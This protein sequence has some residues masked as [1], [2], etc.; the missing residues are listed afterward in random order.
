MRLPTP[1]AVAKSFSQILGSPCQAMEGQAVDFDPRSRALLVP[2][3]NSLG[4]A[5]SL[6][7]SDQDLAVLL[8]GAARL[9]QRE[10]LQSAL[11]DSRFDPNDLPELQRIF[12]PLGFLFG[13]QNDGLKSG[14]VLADPH[15]SRSPDVEAVLLAPASRLDLQVTV[16]GY[17]TG[18]LSLLTA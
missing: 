10:S 3:L 18:R 8:V 16:Q 9:D 4:G 1:L 11:S 6:V 13:S 14:H 15:A 12:A 7:I 5:Q 17:G 2:F